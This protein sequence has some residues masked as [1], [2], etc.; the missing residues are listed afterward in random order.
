VTLQSVARRYSTALFDVVRTSG[1]LDA[2][3]TALLALAEAVAGNPDLARVFGS[4]AISI[5]KKRAVANAV[6]EKIGADKSV[7]VEITRL[8]AALA[9]RD[10]LA[11]IGDVATAFDARVM[12]ERKIVQADVTTAVPLSAEKSAA[13]GQALGRAVGGASNVKI[14]ARVDPS[15]LGGVVA[16]VGSVVFDGS[17]TRQL[18]KMKA[19]LLQAQNK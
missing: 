14:N 11:L 3:H 17:V 18:E 2:S 12:T 7:P 6:L 19:Q 10:R 16:R 4:P 15:I 8:V 1:A 13:L 9:D 5:E